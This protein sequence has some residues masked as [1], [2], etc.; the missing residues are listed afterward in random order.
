MALSRCKECSAEI[1]ENAEFCPKCGYKYERQK[2][3]NWGDTLINVIPGP[4][5]I[6]AATAI[7]A[8]WTFFCDKQTKENE[9]LQTMIESAVSDNAVKER[10]AIQIVSYLAKENRLSPK[11][12]LSV[13]GTVVRNGGDEKLRGEAYDAVQN[14]TDDAKFDQYDR[15]EVFCLRAALTPAQNQRQKNIHKIEQF[16][17]PVGYI[18]KTKE[19]KEACDG[20]KLQAASK[21]FSLTQHLS[22]PQ[23]VIDLL[24]SVFACDKDPDMIE[25]VIPTLW[26]AIENRDQSGNGSNQDIIGFLDRAIE[27]IGNNI[28]SLKKAIEAIDQINSNQPGANVREARLSESMEASLSEIME[29]SLSEIRQ[30]SLSEIRQVSLSEIRQA[31][32]SEIRLYLAR[33]LITKNKDSQN[34]LT[35]LQEIAISKDLDLC[36]DTRMLFDEIGRATQ[37][38]ILL[39]IVKTGSSY[40]RCE[41]NPEA[42]RITR[43]R[44]PQRSRLTNA[45][46]FGQA[47]R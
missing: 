34:S 6:S 13:L 21:L 25:K 46:R 24:L 32:R 9:K 4:V 38:P 31:S 28:D 27:H 15:L 43:K 29:A 20:L 17:H 37:S 33:A 16:V 11:F 36:D 3:R 1:A 7:L 19:A 41:K 40:L 18:S 44:S 5:V 42:N 47:S 26:R 14:L 12:A 8:Y 23:T 35:H 10:T 39:G 22:D 45:G 30:A 2:T